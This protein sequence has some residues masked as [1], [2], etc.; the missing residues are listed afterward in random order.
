MRA[1]GLAYLTASLFARVAMAS[2][3]GPAHKRAA[4]EIARPAPADELEPPRK[5]VHTVHPEDSG[6]APASAPTAAPGPFNDKPTGGSFDSRMH[7]RNRYFRRKPDFAALAAQFADFAAIVVTDSRGRVHVDWKDPACSVA[8]TRALLRADYGLK[9]ELP[10]GFLCPPVPQRV[11]YV[12]WIEDLLAGTIETAIK[13]AHAVRIPDEAT[14][15]DV[16]VGAS[17]IYPLLALSLHPNWKMIGTDINEEALRSARA[18]VES[19]GLQ[20]KIRLELV[21]SDSVLLETVRK[22]SDVIDFCMCNPPFFAAEEDARKAS[23]YRSCDAKVQELVTPGG[24]QAFVSRMIADSQVL[25]HRV[26]WYTTMV[27]HKSSLTAA[28]AEIKSCGASL[29]RST[30]FFQGKTIRWAV[31]WSF[32]VEEPPVSSL[33]FTSCATPAQLRQRLDAAAAHYGGFT[34]EWPPE[35]TRSVAAAGAASTDAERVSDAESDCA[36]EMGNGAGGEN[37]EWVGGG[38]GGGGAEGGGGVAPWEH[39]GSA[40]PWQKSPVDYKT[41]ARGQVF[42]ESW[43]RRARRAKA[44]Q[45][46]VADAS[47]ALFAFIVVMTRVGLPAQHASSGREGGRGVGLDT[48]QDEWMATVALDRDCGVSKPVARDT[49]RLFDSLASVLLRHVSSDPQAV[50]APAEG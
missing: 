16:G 22:Q 37:G 25:R 6:P 27:G 12:H 40:S 1:V 44:G 41:V 36:D 24:E 30:T 15:L 45:H 3:P 14:G 48:E 39:P 43:T 35:L 20:A 28:M 17:A 50:V 7:P 47:E 23:H 2:P 31:A 11:N 32:E 13:S 46:V 5:R 29:V 9:W 10:R 33:R 38:G 21:G 18:N 26:R 4:A 19:N 8:L 34:L 49:A 42:R